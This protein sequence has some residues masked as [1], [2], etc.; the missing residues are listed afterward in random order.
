MSMLWSCNILL[1]LEIP[2]M[3]WTL[4][5]DTSVTNVAPSKPDLLETVCG[6]PPTSC[7]TKCANVMVGWDRSLP[8]L[9]L[10]L[11]SVAALGL[12]EVLQSLQLRICSVL[13]ALEC[14]G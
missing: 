5:L 11:L 8:S 7:D 4:L 2:L 6:M 12:P 10:F 13:S 1:L 14:K 3:T 9:L